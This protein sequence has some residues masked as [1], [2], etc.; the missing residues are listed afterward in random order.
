MEK[1][2]RGIDLIAEERRRQI[3]DMGFDTVHDTI[4]WNDGQLTKAAV[5]YAKNTLPKG[6]SNDVVPKDWP[7]ADKWWKPSSDI[8]DLVKAG[9]L[10]AAQIDVYLTK[11]GNVPS[12]NESATK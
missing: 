6:D 11:N 7:W 2:L 1:R 3:E 10:I 5:C 12:E 4:L 9:A 8:R